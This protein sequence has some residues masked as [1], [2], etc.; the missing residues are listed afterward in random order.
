[1]VDSFTPNVDAEIKP[2][3]TPEQEAQL[4]ADGD[5]TKEAAQH[6]HAEE[7]K[8]ELILGKFKTQ[9]DLAEAYQSLE[10]KYSAEPRPAGDV[11]GLLNEAGDYYS[12]NGELSENHYKQFDSNGI[13]R[14]YVDRY[15][16]GVNA[17]AD[18]ES[19]RLMG[20]IGGE[21]NFSQMSE[22]MSESLPEGE[23]TAY[24]NVIDKG[25]GEEVSVL[26]RGMYAR[27][28]AATGAGS[29]QLRGKV[30]T[31]PAGFRS[32]AEVMAAMGD[33][34]YGTDVAFRAEVERKLS[35]TPDSVF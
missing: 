8:E 20:T 24:N 3:F 21:D 12:E 4:I 23:I 17:T 2:A 25:T 13:P 7:P 16:E 35:V 1:M 11:G 32:R 34:K 29:T 9:E 10:K 28:T 18:A 5:I 26:L 6:P 14:E 27:Y 33:P 19:A 31:S 30:S 22:W 15:L